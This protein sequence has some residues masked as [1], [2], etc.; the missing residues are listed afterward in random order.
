MM[1][2]GFYLFSTLSVLHIGSTL[3]IH[4]VILFK[5]VFLTV[6]KAQSV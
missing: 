4:L 5:K 1:E 2:Q 6:A 3:Q